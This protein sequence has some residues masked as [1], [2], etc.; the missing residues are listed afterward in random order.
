[1][2]GVKLSKLVEELNLEIIM[3]SNDYDEIEINNK[4]VNRPGIQLSGFMEEYP[5]KR[6]QIIGNVEYH[7]YMQM[8]P[9]LRY[10]RFRGI[11]T[12]EIP[13]LIFSYDREVTQD[14]IDLANYY[15]RT[16]LIS[17]YPT[18]RLI[19]KLSMFLEKNLA[20]EITIH[21]GLLEVFGVGV[22]I[23]GQS[24]VGKSETALDLITKGHR[25]IADDVVDIKKI[26]DVLHGSCP[27]N[28]RHFM[29]IRGLGILDIRKLYGVGSIK[30][31]N[32]IDLVIELE[33][34]DDSKE[35]DRLGL[36]DYYD[37]ILGVKVPKLMVPVKPGRNIAM[38]IEVAVRNLRQKNLG[39]NS[40]KYLSHKLFNEMNPGIEKSEYIDH[41]END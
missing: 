10:E 21:G 6:I 7:F 20:D 2:K 30:S 28:I 36:D 29:E 12:Q 16:V 26:D 14:I 18:T 31:E 1:M 11:L 8:D 37:E 32:A 41:Y 23:K 13:C 33:N 40:A 35:Y 4:H 9:E 39:F 38:V 17:S 5:Y 22:L 3:A 15:N 19:S 24:S 27:E 25:L 34:W